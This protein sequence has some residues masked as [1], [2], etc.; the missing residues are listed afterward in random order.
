MN[1]SKN[2]PVSEDF[3]IVIV[4]AGASGITAAVSASLEGARVLLLEK[5][6]IVGGN[7]T[8]GHVGP[9]M[10]RYEKNTAADKINKLLSTS[11]Q[12]V[13]DFEMA[14]ILLMRL[15]KEHNIT[16]YLNCAL[17]DVIKE[18][19]RITHVI[20]TSQN[21]LQAVSAKVF[22]DATGDGVLSYLAGE[23]VEVGR[24]D[25][26]TQPS[27]IMFTVEGIAE[28]QKLI[29]Q[30]EEM[31]TP[32]KKGNYLELCK[33]ACQNGELPHSVNIVRLYSGLADDERMVNATQANG[34]D[35][36]SLTDYTKAQHEL[37]EQMLS[38]I[39]FLKNNVEGFENIRIKDSSD[40]IGVRESRR[41][42]GKYI[43]TAADMIEKRRFHDVVVHNAAFPIDIHNSSGA[44]QAEGDGLPVQIE[45]YDIP[46]RALIP[47]KN[48]N[49][50]LS[51][52]A[53]IGT[54]RAHASYRVMNIAMN[55]GEAVG[56]TSAL[57]VKQEL[58]P[59]DVDAKDIQNVLTARGIELFN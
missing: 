52:C 24:L 30:H 22:V 39:E 41:V 42:M 59:C 32:L 45:K 50:L 56:A 40:I 14:K 13:Q 54:H 36:L 44:G 3:D 37:R 6:G 1:Y 53:I 26:L 7:L 16:L 49:L 31:D 4:G 19:D 34:Y 12:V 25:G 58:L 28:W 57:A 18:N 38:V 23:D 9:P 2:I 48:K 17:A 20:Y 33:N 51:G 5:S 46:Y 8:A 55:V 35:T 21:G 15:V 43:L 29:C 11:G 47:L 27:T 10:G